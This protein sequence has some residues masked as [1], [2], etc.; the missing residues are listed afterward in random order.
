MRRQKKRMRLTDRQKVRQ[1]D[2]QT[3][4]QMDRQT[5]LIAIQTLPQTHCRTDTERKI[6]R[7]DRRDRKEENE[8]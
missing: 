6:E 2:R 5:R 3:E 7:R 1:L 4:R 8:S